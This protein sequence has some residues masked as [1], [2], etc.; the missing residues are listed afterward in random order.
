MKWTGLT[1]G[2]ATGK[3]T[4]KKLLEGFGIPVVDADQISH[5]LTEQGA[6]GYN[7][8]LSHFGNEILTADQS[9]DRKKLGQI[10]FSD[11]ARKSELENIL[12]PLIQQEVQIQREMH[13]HRDADICFYDVPLLFEKNLAGNFDHTVLV[14]CDTKTQMDRLLNR[15]HL[16][17]T[18]AFLRIG[19]QLNL[20]EKVKQADFCIDNSGSVHELETQLK[21][22]IIKL[23][24]AASPN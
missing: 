5:K 14:W 23:K 6:A 17:E 1:G 20:V 11:A 2:I 18:E 8:I 15:D 22:L 9:L 16:S 24:E 3:S 4:V 19:N 10:I 12:H 7:G 21:K 13:Q